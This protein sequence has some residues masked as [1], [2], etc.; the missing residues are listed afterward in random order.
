VKDNAVETLREPLR[1][2]LDVEAEHAGAR[3]RLV[4]AVI[5]LLAGAWLA[6]VAA[7]SSAWLGVVALASVAFALRWMVGY[8][9]VKRMTSGAATHYLEI[10][11]ERVT[12]ATGVEHRTIPRE[13]IARIE[14]DDDRLV[15]VLVLSTGEELAIEPIYG[16]LGLR[17]L[18]ETLQRY[19][20]PRRG[21]LDPGCTELNP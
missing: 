9:K 20:D 16:E 17:E 3:L 6:W 15:L 4:A 2:M 13:S 11:S 1:L 14:L 18:G 21:R 7:G 19:L 12:L 8:R 5:A 10:T